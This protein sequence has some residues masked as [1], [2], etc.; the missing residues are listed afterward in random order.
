MA[1]EIVAVDRDLGTLTL[2]DRRGK[3]RTF[4]R[5]RLPARGPPGHPHRSGPRGGARQ[6]HAHRQRLG[7]RP[8][9]QGP[10]RLG[11]P[12][13]R[14]GPPRRRA[15]GEGLG[16]RPADRGRRRGVPRRRRRPRRPP[17]RLP[18]AGPERRVG[19]CWPTTVKGSKE[20]RSRTTSPG[21]HRQGRADRGAPVHRHLAGGQACPAR[22]RPLAGR[23]ATST[24]RPGPAN[25]SAGRTGTRR[26]SP[27]RGSTSPAS[28]SLPTSTALLGRVEELIDFVT[29]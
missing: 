11:Q 19:C 17:P 3:R 14:R 13:L 18:S 28:V 4:P 1:G 20:S 16:R 21:P 23:P 6:A 25:S 27:G 26:T 5:P 7:R 22:H 8:R 2:E 15:G 24:G 12:D 29:S 10:G 9:R